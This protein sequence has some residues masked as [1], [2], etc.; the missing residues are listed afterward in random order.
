MT[1][2]TLPENRQ[3]DNIRQKDDAS[4]LIWQVR[5]FFCAMPVRGVIQWRAHGHGLS[6]GMDVVR[7]VIILSY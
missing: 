7:A 6:M 1:D 2:L 3:K 4:A 5:F